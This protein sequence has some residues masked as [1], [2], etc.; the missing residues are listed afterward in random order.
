MK[1]INLIYNPFSGGGSFKGRLDEYI[2]EL[3]AV[4]FVVHTFRFTN[5]LDLEEY[6]ASEIGRKCDVIAV[7]GGD[8]TVNTVINS[9]L[10]HGIVAPLAIIPSGTAND[11]AKFLDMPA[12]ASNF[13]AAIKRGN[14]VD[15]D[16]G[17]ANERY[18]INVC[19]TGLFSHVSQKVN[20]NMK[21]T[22]GKLAYYL[23]GLGELPDFEPISVRISNS[24]EVIEP[25]IFLFLAL[26]TAGAGGFGKLVPEASVTDGLLD[27]VAF[28]ACSLVDLGKLFIKI[29]RQDYINDPNIIYFRDNFVKV[30]LLEPNPKYDTC[31]ID[32]EYGP[33][34]P[35]T[36]RNIPNRIPL[37]LP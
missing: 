5:S 22:L 9:V 26:N 27:F 17:Q 25:D 29:L 12:D 37:I 21:T 35:L 33:K 23:K 20:K 10:R 16:I 11:F 19:G 28:R 36:I 4:G 2:A 14:A 3:Q 31:D 13:A 30:E 24:H 7:S 18:F 6:F 15:V 32:G 34:L 1:S 8:G